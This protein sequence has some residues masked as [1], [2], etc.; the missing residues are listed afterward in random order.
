M[1]VASAAA[2]GSPQR[3]RIIRTDPCCHQLSPGD[4]REGH[5]VG[6]IKLSRRH[7]KPRLDSVW[8]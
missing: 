8:L 7:P 6:P 3:I 1:S 5:P 2:D 4:R